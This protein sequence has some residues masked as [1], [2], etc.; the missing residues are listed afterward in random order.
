MPKL[1]DTTLLSILSR[2]ESEARNSLSTRIA[3]D[4]N[5]TARYNAELYGDEIAG[6]SKVVSEDVKDVVE[7]DMPALVRTI[8]NSG[9]INKFIPLNP[10]NEEDV[11][12][13]GEKTDFV[14][15]IIRGQQDSYK[16]NY[17]FI[18]SNVMYRNG[19]LKCVYTEEKTTEVE[20]FENVPLNGELELTQRIE[21][22]QYIDDY[23][24]KEIKQAENGL[25]EYKVKITKK[26]EKVELLPVPNDTFLISN[27]ASSIN[28]AAM[29]GDIGTK[30]RGA[31]LSEGYEMALVKQLPRS[32]GNSE[33]ATARQYRFDEEGN[34]YPGDYGEWANELVEV[35]DMYPLIDYDMDGIAERRHI[36]KSGTFVLLN[37]P[38]DR[39]PYTSSSAI[40]TPYSAIGDGRAKQVLNIA[41]VK[42]SLERGMLDNTYL[43]NNPKEHINSNVN[44]DDIQNDKI[45]GVVR[46]KGETPP[47]SNVYSHATEYVGDK[48]LLAVQYQDQKKS[49]L[50]GNQLTSQGLN[51]DEINNET[52]TRFKGVEKAEAAK[53]E[54]V[55]R[56]IAE[57]GYQKAA[58]DIVWFAQKFFSGV[59]SINYQGKHLNIDPSKWKLDHNVGVE[60]G[61]GSGNNE[62]T[63][64]NLTALYQIHTQLKAEQSPLTDEVKRYNVLSDLTKA[65]EFT[66]V[67]RYFNNPEEP[68]Q[69]VVTQNEQLNALALQQQE[70][71]QLLQQQID[72]PLVEAET[73]KAQKDLLETTEK[74]KLEW[75][76]LQENIR[77]FDISTAQKSIKQE[78]DTALEITKLELDNNTDIAGGLPTSQGNVQ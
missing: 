27:G 75:A 66:D 45:G 52:A 63:V 23:E 48:S 71:I 10:D 44:R 60:I 76:E 36:I 31:L 19:V 59:L 68:T 62:Q 28:D 40:M 57:I 39:N 29:T 78:E 46:H 20:V 56:N 8:L 42:T 24:V 64:G 33:G 72:N 5:I 14:D 21:S 11:N 34:P 65:L 15:W 51:A 53:L 58:L 55:V 77:Q 17:D 1:D 18:K 6:R 74:M 43:H 50:V 13:A 26:V 32:N 3:D 54:L 30:T 22:I 4:N 41:R 47:Q 38:F 25:F 69:L 61:L 70:Q 7:S 2:Y 73:I 35:I 16:T 37:E 9:P 12:E 67:S 49:K